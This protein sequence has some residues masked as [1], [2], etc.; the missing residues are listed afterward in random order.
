MRPESGQ[1][2]AFG[3]Q[4]VALLFAAGFGIA[5]AV[6]AELERWMRGEPQVIALPHWWANLPLNAC[7]WFFVGLLPGVVAS[8]LTRVPGPRQLLY[9]AAL[10]LA[11]A[12]ALSLLL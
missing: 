6:Y 8:R 2:G 5:I 7:I 11:T 3:P 12:A 4:R 9:G 10:G 1:E